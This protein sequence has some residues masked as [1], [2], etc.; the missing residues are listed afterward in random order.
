MTRAEIIIIIIIEKE[1][2]ASSERQ[3]ENETRAARWPKLR[4]VA[5]MT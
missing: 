2:L 1:A 4:K 3:G 5:M